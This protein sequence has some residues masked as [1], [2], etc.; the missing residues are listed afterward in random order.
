[1]NDPN[2][3]FREELVTECL[4][5]TLEES[6]VERFLKICNKLLEKSSCK[7]TTAIS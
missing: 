2:V 3:N 5:T 7:A 4:K 6:S 1:M